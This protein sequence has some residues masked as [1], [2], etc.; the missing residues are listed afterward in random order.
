M[1]KRKVVLIVNP[2][3][4]RQKNSRRDIERFR[5]TLVRHGFDVEVDLTCAPRDATRLA[6]EAVRAEA[7]HIAVLGGDG[8]INEVVQSIVGTSAMLVAWPRGT[9]NVLAR[10]LSLPFDAEQTAEM[11]A[12]GKTQE[13]YL[14]CATL[15]R[16][17]EFE[18][19]LYGKVNRYFLLMA[20]IGLDASVVEGVRAGLKRRIGKGA[21]WYS[22]LEH[23][24]L[25]KPEPFSIEINGKNYEATFATIGK[26][27]SY[28]GGLNITPRAEIAHP[29]F[30]VCIVSARNSLRFV[31]LLTHT[32]RANGVPRS[33]ADVTF[34][35]TTHVRAAGSAAVQIDGELIGRLPMR[36]EIAPQ[37]LKIV[38]P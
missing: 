11:I 30:E 35:R 15:E 32:L 26:A 7:S 2:R 21:F 29:D 25:W 6:A 9:A 24:A 23:L 38:V 16:D 20:G 19:E 28:G 37:P 8:T 34:V 18:E 14:G 5:Q 13:I 27:S 22:G 36:F 33:L 10:E 17:G 31:R 12:R 4:G 3:A 1:M